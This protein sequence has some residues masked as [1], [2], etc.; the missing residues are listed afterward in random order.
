M[1]KG[2][3]FARPTAVGSYDT[4]HSRRTHPVQQPLPPQSTAFSTLSSIAVDELHALER[5]ES[6]RRAEFEARRPEALRR[7]ESENRF[8]V[9]ASN[10]YF[11]HRLSK[12]ATTSPTT[13]PALR[14][15]HIPLHTTGEQHWSGL[16]AERDGYSVHGDKVSQRRLSGPWHHPTLPSSHRS[17]LI[18]SHSSGHLVDQV[19]PAGAGYGVHHYSHPYYPQ[20][21]HAHYRHLVGT[22][23]REDSPSPISSDSDSAAINS[24]SPSQKLFQVVPHSNLRHRS[25]DRSPPHFSSTKWTTDMAHTPSTSPFLGPLRTLNIH[26]TGPSRAPSPVLLPPSTMESHERGRDMMVN[27]RGHTRASSPTNSS[28]LVHQ[29]RNPLV[30]QTFPRKDSLGYALPPSFH[31]SHPHPRHPQHLASSSDIPTPQL[32][33][34][35]S[36]NGSSPGGLGQHTPLGPPPILPPGAG[37]VSSAQNSRAPSPVSWTSS[38]AA[39]Q[40]TAIANAFGGGRREHNHGHLAHSVRVAFGMTPIVPSSST[41]H[42]QSQSGS[43][44]VH[45]FTGLTVPTHALNTNLWDPRSMPA[46]RSGSPPITLPPLKVPGDDED[47][48]DGVNE[49]GVRIKKEDTDDVDMLMD[50][51]DKLS[52]KARKSERVELPGFSQ[53]EAAVRGLPPVISSASTSGLQKMSI[54]FVR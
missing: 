37:I 25:S 41:C 1:F 18:Q 3:S 32:S 8:H 48:V 49:D 42:A 24:R 31:H 30:K 10:P 23:V 29:H 28:A 36:S 19:R 43:G 16:P 35:P 33:S 15:S 2:E 13:T 6:L 4:P 12:S 22:N 9:E 27:D 38:L 50:D 52:G 21:P 5:Q 17:N 40:M 34:G 20:T 26:S 45:S 46:S 11:R 14:P 39:G 7:V 44:R 47:S 54:D 53:F 51:V